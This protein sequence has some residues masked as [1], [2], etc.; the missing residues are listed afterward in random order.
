MAT[1]AFSAVNMVLVDSH[2][3]L[4]DEQFAN[5]LDDVIA[6]AEDAGVQAI[7]TAGTDV[8]SSRV[9][10]DLA[11]RYNIVYAVVGIHPQHADTFDSQTL[12]AIREQA[13]HRKV[14][15]I[16]EVGL[17]FYWSNNPPRAVQEKNFAAH[18]DL[19]AE[20]DKP[21]IIHNRNAD[22]ALR[23]GK[24]R[25]VLHCFAGDLAMA[26][27]AIGLGYRISFAGNVTFK[28]AAELQSVARGLSLEHIVIETDAPYLS[29][30]RGKRNESANVG[31]VAE[32]IAALKN[33]DLALMAQ[34]TTR[35]SIALFGLKDK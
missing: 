22:D 4:D 5:D 33:I 1:S 3:H 32:K 12:A 2:C 28:N 21:V 35:N 16:G 13:L 31:R 19:A 30:V 7:I 17:D 15:G 26:R 25:G 14:V 27:E 18:L 24:P 10:I 23:K 11:E 6:R 34:I 8:A 29:P 20:L 9:A